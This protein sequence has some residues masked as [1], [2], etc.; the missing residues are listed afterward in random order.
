MSNSDE[1]RL[2]LEFVINQLQ[3]AKPGT[4]KAL[5]WSQDEINSLVEEIKLTLCA[6][7]T[8]Y[9]FIF[10]EKEL[11]EGYGTKIWKERLISRVNEIL[12]EI[13]G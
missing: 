5:S 8:S 10:T 4:I 12:A 9:I 6:E 2:A 13:E 11:V 3:K 7:D 1:I